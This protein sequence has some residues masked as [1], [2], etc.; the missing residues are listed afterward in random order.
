MSLIKC[1]ECGKEVSSAAA[2]CPAC[3]AKSRKTHWWIWATVGIGSLV[4]LSAAIEPDYAVEARQFRE[5]CRAIGGINN[6]SECDALYHQRLAQGDAGRQLK[7]EAPVDYRLREQTDQRRAAEAELDRKDCRANLLEKR[8]RYSDLM[9]RGEFWD[10]SLALRICAEALDDQD[11]RAAVQDAEVKAYIA[12]L[13]DASASAEQKRVA[14]QAL[15]RDYP[16]V[17]K[18]R[19][20]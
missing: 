5:A 1:Y 14:R 13:E 15:K 4:A 11:L 20:L 6:R 16:E 8:R 19:R 3:G 17:A 18:A 7:V 9:A 10:A 2:A 12:T